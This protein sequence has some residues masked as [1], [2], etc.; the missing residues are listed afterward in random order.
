MKLRSFSTGIR[1][2]IWRAISG[3]MLGLLLVACLLPSLI[4]FSIA[5]A[6]L[7]ERVDNLANATLATMQDHVWQYDL[8]DAQQLLDSYVK[9]GAVTG[10]RVSDGKYI[11]LSAGTLGG[12]LVG[13]VLEL[14][15]YGAGQSSDV[16]IGTLRL[17]VSESEILEFILV[18]IIATILTSAVFV[19]FT[20]F[21]TLRLLDK[22]L[23]QPL[24]TISNTLKDH[25]GDWGAL[26]I[27]LNDGSSPRRRDE[28]T[29][30]VDAIHGMRDQILSSQAVLE[31]SMAK[32]THVA[33]F[34]RLGYATLDATQ[35]RFIDCDPTFASAFKMTVQ[36]VLDVDVRGKFLG[37][38]L[39]D[40]NPEKLNAIRALLHKG[41]M[42]EG[43]LKFT[44]QDD[45]IRYFRHIIRPFID[46]VTGNSVLEIIILDVTEQ[47]IIEE[48][49][50]QAQKMDAI[51]MLTGGVAH[52]FNN[53]LAIISGNIELAL[54][55]LEGPEE[56]EFLEVALSAVGSGATL[57]QQLLSFARKQ[58]LSPTRFDAAELMRDSSAL[59]GTSV[60]EAIDLEIVSD[61]DLWGTFAD[62]EKLKTTLLNLVVNSRDAM[63]DGGLLTIEIANCRLD[64]DYAA[65][66]MDVIPG[67]YV[68]ISVNDTGYGMSQE[69]IQHAIEPFFT[70]K[71]VGKGTG[72]GLPMAFGFAKQSG[73]HLEVYSELG[74]GTSVKMYLPRS[75]DDDVSDDETER[76]KQRP[77][78]TGMVVFLI[79]D[80][81]D[82]RTMFKIMLVAMGCVVHDAEDGP[83]ALKIAETLTDVDLILSDVI[84][85]RGMDGN[86][87]VKRLSP[88][89]P[90][91]A[92][93]FMSGFSESSII[94][95]GRLDAKV[96][97]LQKPFGADDLVSAIVSARAAKRKPPEE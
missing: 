74:I 64:K 53:L 47:K 94:Q 21:L 12:N 62:P 29:G 9:F 33:L 95:N 68:C 63:P 22:T 69:T 20:A 30:L 79:E 42:S 60:G 27:D 92:V 73:G 89:F 17:E 96:T 45:E 78:F 8:E 61:D 28:L 52:D 66:H 3:P 1:R 6:R 11:D 34:A 58:P 44:L 84:L 72:L 14:P 13:Y 35:D 2:E 31:A 81:S 15:L 37:T 7:K 82:L 77:D 93:I 24:L 25:S 71:G 59:F 51:G 76:T 4:Y 49:L 65:T 55:S 40:E 97:L 56:R 16:N 38:F 36:E 50:L 32:L 41:K 87:V 85:P 54:L 80:N 10:A 43:V 83:Q 48:Q 57:T 46:K 5:E 91:A 39:R 88:M 70:T 18:R 67:E 90:E 86:E 75:A 23:L 19:F 26:N